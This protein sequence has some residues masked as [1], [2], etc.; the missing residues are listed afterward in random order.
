VNAAG[1]YASQLISENQSIDHTELAAGLQ[2]TLSAQLK[3]CIGPERFRG[4]GRLIDWRDGILPGLDPIATDRL[5]HPGIRR[6]LH[7][8][9]SAAALCVYSLLPWAGELSRL[10]LC[11][12]GGF[13]D[14]RFDV[15]L[16]TGARGT[17]PV[18]HALAIGDGGV[19]GITARLFDY[20]SPRASRLA[21]TYAGVALPEPM[22]PW[23][24]VAQ[25]LDRP[26]PSQHPAVDGLQLTKLALG[27]ARIFPR[28]PIRLLYLFL[29][30]AGR[31]GAHVFD[32]HRASLGAVV[33]ATREAAVTFTSSSFHELWEG[34]SGRDDR[35]MRGI[36]AEL[37]RRYTVALPVSACL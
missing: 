22:A 29:E 31:D 18:I 13:N 30:P 35:A 5:V 21:S 8:P 25:A 26:A 4:A 11:D 10:T 36:V 1:H 17:P 16:P 24:H 33:A 32:G 34:W 9:A 2:R 3:R 12:I 27:L 28:R 37:S 14:I 7:E 6:R 20:V 19:V 23:Q 15:R